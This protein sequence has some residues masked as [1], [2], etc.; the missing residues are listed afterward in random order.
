MLKRFL[1]ALLAPLAILAF[2]ATQASAEDFI[3]K[4]VRVKK[5]G[6]K[7]VGVVI[8]EDAETITVEIGKGSTNTF[9]RADLESVES[10]EPLWQEIEKRKATAKTG[11]DWFKIAMDLKKEGFDKALYRFALDKALAVDPE[12]KKAR[13]E[14]GFVSVTDAAGKVHW[15][16]PAQA[17]KFEETAGNLK[18]VE[19][20]MGERPW[21]GLDPQG[22][23]Y[24]IVVDAPKDK[25][26]YEIITNCPRRIAE[27]YANFMVELRTHLVELI[28]KKIGVKQI[29][30]QKVPCEVCKGSGKDGTDVC[31]HCG[32]RGEEPA[33]VF[34]CNSHKH[35]MDVTGLDEGT[36]GY[37]RWG[38]FDAGDCKRP[39][40]A[41][42]GTFGLGGNTFGVLAHEGTH[43]LEHLM[44][45]GD[46]HRAMPERPGWLA[47]GLAVYF[48]DGLDISKRKQG[49]FE[50]EIPRDRLAGLR[51]ELANGPGKYYPI[52]YFTGCSVGN[53]QDPQKGGAALYAYSWSLIYYML[54]TTDKFTFKGKPID[55]K[56]AF[57]KFFLDNCE[58]GSV[59][60]F[61]DG[62]AH[63]GLAR[64]MG[65]APQ[66]ADQCL[67]ELEKVWREYVLKL[68]LKA[69]GEFDPKDKKKF[70]SKELAFEVTL[71]GGKKK[72]KHD[73]SLVPPEELIALPPLNE[74]AALKANGGQGRLMICVGANSERFEISPAVDNVL[75]VVQ[76]YKFDAWNDL[77]KDPV[78]GTLAGSGIETR[79]IEFEGTE[80][81]L[82]GY[83]D[84]VRGS[85]KGKLL[86][87][88]TAARI[89]HVIAYA[90]KDAYNDYKD[91]LDELL[92]SF[93][94][95]GG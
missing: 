9:D 29:P 50:V 85:Q 19:E 58:K 31:K 3:H 66:D 46:E 6:R 73:W 21:D 53:F 65:V 2:V 48:G 5:N 4:H 28:E 44:W 68:P 75:G 77:D 39:I 18:A 30:W 12:H 22:N 81:K 43:Q 95:T 92:G 37:Y 13:E 56:E 93:A 33:K 62:K 61:G 36:G 82:P 91:E 51:R 47:E 83:R 42:H 32:G 72:S 17:K 23:P 55:L 74:A 94:I 54:N 87:L 84:N 24:R 49:K 35:F 88:R 76:R 79:V 90:D 8:A 7:V 89:Y 71:P 25:P 20:E 63:L 57:G 45:K 38:Y 14:A 40:L 27:D 86:V 69:I 59:G 26:Q 67:A 60:E 78:E 34:L 70:A 15:L 41:F 80:K 1:P 52:K 10:I 11:D 64:A 16:T